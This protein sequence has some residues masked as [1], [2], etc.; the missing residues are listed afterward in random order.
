MY[1]NQCHSWTSMFIGSLDLCTLIIS[2][3]QNLNK[4][5]APVFVCKWYIPANSKY[6]S[7]TC[8]KHFKT[9]PLAQPLLNVISLHGLHADRLV[10]HWY[11]TQWTQSAKWHVCISTYQGYVN[12]SG[13]RTK[14]LCQNISMVTSTCKMTNCKMEVK[15]KYTAPQQRFMYESGE[16]PLSRTHPWPITWSKV[17][18]AIHWTYFFLQISS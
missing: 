8:N 11:W 15:T 6:M 4:W 2:L 10:F 14:V 1:Q 13:C 12:M 9:M 5:T 17:F 18:L 3:L 16:F 7:T